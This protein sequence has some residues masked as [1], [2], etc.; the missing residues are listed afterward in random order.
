MDSVVVGMDSVVG[1]ANSEQPTHILFIED[2]CRFASQK[3]TP[4]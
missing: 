3:C 4:Y 1:D 2:K